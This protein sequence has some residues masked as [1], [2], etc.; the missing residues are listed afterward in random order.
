MKKLLS[1]LLCMTLI[2][3]SFGRT[4][5]AADDEIPEITWEEAKAQIEE[6][7]IEGGFVNLTGTGL[8]MWIPDF[9]EESE[10]EYEDLADG[11]IAVYGD[12]KAVREAF[13]WYSDTDAEDLDEYM[14]ELEDFE[15]S[16]GPTKYLVNGRE[17]LIYLDDE[18]DSGLVSLEDEN[19]NL[20]DFYFSPISDNDYA[21]IAESMIASIQP[22]AK[23]Y[24]AENAEMA[25]GDTIVITVEYAEDW[26]K[27]YKMD[28]DMI[29]LDKVAVSAWLPE[30]YESAEVAPE[31]IKEGIFA[32]YESE[33]EDCL[34]TF[35]YK[36]AEEKDLES[37]YKELE[38][39]KNV[40][41]LS[42]TLVN[43]CAGILYDE[44]KEDSST[45]VF[46]TVNGYFFTYKMYHAADDD[47]IVKCST[48]LASLQSENDR[49]KDRTPKGMILEPVLWED[50]ED[51]IEENEVKG[52]FVT[53]DDIDIQ[54]WIPDDVK[55][56][57]SD[58]SWEKDG[59]IAK[60]E[61]GNGGTMTVVYRDAEG[62]SLFED[63][64]EELEK[65]E[66][67]DYF[68]AVSINRYGALSY[69][70]NEDTGYIDYETEKGYVLSLAFEG[71]DDSDFMT[72]AQI[73]IYSVMP[74]DEEADT[75]DEVQ[76]TDASDKN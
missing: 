2:F 35:A 72:M 62:A 24:L 55:A 28:G 61:D 57:K 40:S 16:G 6:D 49:L 8:K 20:V 7:E 21:G 11:F 66:E 36:N 47:L 9:L 23:D 4:V 15:W 56:A 53:F 27:E 17:A 31:D 22:A 71:I 64:W 60:Y 13:V 39:D 34:L 37:L 63:Y 12:N 44:D 67:L 73:I 52:G 38:K 54:M 10:L 70:R 75:D 68:E 46:E 76:S 19:G 41:G 45:I 5:Y 3:A 59:I 65:D 51:Y 29:S 25:D 69:E 30:G 48:V 74:A 32:I 58:K 1:M 43:G 18:E 42:T 14:E 33:D 50:A 26:I